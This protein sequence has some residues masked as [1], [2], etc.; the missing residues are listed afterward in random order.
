MRT[1]LKTLV[2]QGAAAQDISALLNSLT[3][4][5]RLDEVLEVKGKLIGQLYRLVQGHNT[6]KTSE[7]LPSGTAAGETYVYEGRNSLPVFS[8][9]QKRLTQTA[10]GTIFGYNHQA[11]RIITGPGYFVVKQGDGEREGE[12]LFD[13]TEAPPFEPKGW[14]AIA[15]NDQGLSRYVFANMHDWVRRVAN[16][17]FVGCAFKLGVDQDTYFSL[18]S[19]D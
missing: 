2:E 16:G 8:R 14:P 10:D 13:Y 15:P 6:L 12:V 9:F 19:Q 3:P 4:L 17:V 11:N 7:L 1:Q 5:H 18:T